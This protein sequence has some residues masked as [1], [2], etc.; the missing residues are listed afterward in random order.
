MPRRYKFRHTDV[1]SVLQS[2]I[3]SDDDAYCFVSGFHV[4]LDFH[5]IFNG[6]YKHKSEEDGFWIYLRHDLHMNLHDTEEGHAYWRTLKQKCQ[7]YYELT[8]TREQF[9]RRYGKNYL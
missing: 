5:H 8:H 3:A 4:N 9:I 1:P 2:D 6:A 7:E